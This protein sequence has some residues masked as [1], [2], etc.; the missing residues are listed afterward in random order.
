MDRSF[1]SIEAKQAENQAEQEKA[2]IKNKFTIQNI[3]FS[4][5]KMA[6]KLTTKA[7][8]SRSRS[9]VM[10]LVT[11]E[12]KEDFVDG[13]D[14][15][16]TKIA[17]NNSCEA[18]SSTTPLISQSNSL[19]YNLIEAVMSVKAKL[20]GSSS[21]SS[22]RLAST[23]DQNSLQLLNDSESLFSTKNPSSQAPFGVKRMSMKQPKYLRNVGVG[24]GAVGPMHQ[25]SIQPW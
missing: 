7:S 25:T 8:R 17:H 15:I 9:K 12:Y 14:F 5:A 21:N 20:K 3:S 4:N 19:I 6:K 10:G 11:K 2:K 18:K 22:R 16:D 24:P 1:N 23:H 13:C